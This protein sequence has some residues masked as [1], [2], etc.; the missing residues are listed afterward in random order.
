MD[1]TIELRSQGRSVREIA[2]ALKIPGPRSPVPWRR[3]KSM[4][5]R[6]GLEPALLGIP[7]GATW[8][9]PDGVPWSQDQEVL[10]ENGR[11]KRRTITPPMCG[12]TKYST[13]FRRKTAERYGADD[14]MLRRPTATV[15]F[16][17]PLQPYWIPAR[18][19]L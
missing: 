19:F 6:R 10:T 2:V 17:G 3:P 5:R 14:T 4:R 8:G 7:R 1:R 16:T 9:R 15:W 13:N 11:H 12:P 18:R